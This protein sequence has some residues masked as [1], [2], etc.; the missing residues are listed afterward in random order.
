[1]AEIE[2]RCDFEED[3]PSLEISALLCPIR[4]SIAKLAVLA[5]ADEENYYA[6]A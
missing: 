1:L 2:S 5:T 3:L 6:V 4:A